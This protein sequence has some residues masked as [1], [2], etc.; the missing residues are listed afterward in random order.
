MATPLEQW[1]EEQAKLTKPDKIYWCNGS[2]EEAHDLINIGMKDEQI[3]EHKIFALLNQEKWPNAYLHRSHHTDVARTE[4]LTYV[5]H[6]N[7]ALAGPNNNW[8]DPVE[9]KEKMRILSDGCMKGRTMYVLPYTMGHP[10]S[11]YAKAC[12]QLTDVSYVAVS[13]RIMTRMSKQVIEKIGNRSDFVKGLHSVG[14]FN[15]EKRFIMHFPEEHLV[16]SVGSG[17]G[18]NALLG[19]KCFSLRIASW[20]GYQ[21]HWLAEHMV[22]LGVE[23]P[24]GKIYYITAAM[25]SACG[26]TNLA[27]LESVLPGYKVW[28]LG[29]DIAWLNVGP[30]GRLYAI[31]PEAGLFGVAPGTSMSTNPNMIRTLK[32]DNFYPTLFTNTA[33]DLDTNEPWWEGLDVSIPQNLLDWQGKP[34]D[35]T[36]NTKAA[37]PNS[38]FTVSI[39]NSPTLSKEFDNPKGVPISAIILGGRRTHL[40]PLVTEAFNWQHGVFIGARTGSETTAAASHKVGVLRRDPMAMLPFCGYN[41]GDYFK[42]WL[43]LGKKMSQ[44]PRIYGVNWFRVDEDDKFIWPG[45]GDN[46]RVLKWIIER[47]TNQVGAKE[48]PI[49]LLPEIKDLNLTG[50]NIPKVKLD[51]LFEVNAADW[52]IELQDI[53]QF[54]IQFGDSMPPE[55]WQ[56]YHTLS[57]KLKSK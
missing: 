42:H 46:I 4:H 10:D 6:P 15:P 30:D 7:K 33:L 5:C 48:T 25:P 2:D 18:G 45:F 32:A 51:K 53:E 16:W 11:P 54:L 55:L 52:Q 36:K 8:M 34:W 24:Q 47:V 39:Y 26:K 22:I 21:E 50:L 57:K 56:E 29:D 1:V 49:G 9:A 28:T 20:L 13:M 40:I 35:T 27:M 12:I 38:R 17:Y 44:P 23:D 41:M 19:K 14:D 31:N 37:H 43:N 3:D